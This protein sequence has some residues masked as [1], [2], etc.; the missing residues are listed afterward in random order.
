[1]SDPDHE[2]PLADKWIQ[3]VLDRAKMGTIRYEECADVQVGD[4][5]D[6]VTE[7]GDVIERVRVVRTAT[8]K[9]YESL[10]LLNIFLKPYPTDDVDDLVE[11]LNQHYSDAIWPATTVKV[12][13]WDPLDDT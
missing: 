6:L 9:V 2:I 5:V 13:A 3:P 7:Q 12:I 10:A 11:G 1:M 4:V 8:C